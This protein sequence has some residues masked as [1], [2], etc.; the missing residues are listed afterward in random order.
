MDGEL[1]MERIDPAGLMRE[2]YRIEGL[3]AAECRSIFLEWAIALPAGVP[4]EAAIGR[5]LE[6]C[7]AEG[8]P[9]TDVLRAGLD[10]PAPP[11]RRGGRGG[12]GGQPER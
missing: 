9:M 3:G 4:P 10:P 11:Q 12:R 7:G 8:H 2:A 6:V 1:D 5:V